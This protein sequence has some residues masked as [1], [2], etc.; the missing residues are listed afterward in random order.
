MA[1]CEILVVVVCIYLCV[2]VLLSAFTRAIDSP[3]ASCKCV[4]VSCSS[5]VIIS[6]G[7]HIYV[8]IFLSFC[9]GSLRLT[10]VSTTLSVRLE[11]NVLLA[12]WSHH[13]R[14]A[15][16]SSHAWRRH[17]ARRRHSHS[18]WHAH[19]R[20][21]HHANWTWRRHHAAWR[22]GDAATSTVRLWLGLGGD[23]SINR[24]SETKTQVRKLVP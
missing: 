4:L 16:W 15:W 17:H 3:V 21:R 14:W 6:S 9:A 11:K 24:Q 10:Q 2:L 20:R 12:W 18:W 19:A 5:G 23:Y 22:A 8:H 7:H 1:K 13:R